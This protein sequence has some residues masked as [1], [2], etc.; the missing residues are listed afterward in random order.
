M[1]RGSVLRQWEHQRDIGE[2]FPVKVEVLDEEAYTF[3][4]RADDTIGQLK[5]EIS[6]VTGIPAR[7][8][9]VRNSVVQEME[10]S[11]ALSYYNV[12]PLET[13]RCRVKCGYCGNSRC[14]A[15]RFFVCSHYQC[16]GSVLY[17]RCCAVCGEGNQLPRGS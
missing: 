12:R 6:N 4:M 8:L 14:Q 9:F 16:L 5:D 15:E 1:P 13:I 7:L 10:N 2:Y 3:M 11:K 17:L